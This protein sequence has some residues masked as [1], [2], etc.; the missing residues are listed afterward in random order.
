MRSLA[1]TLGRRISCAL[2]TC[3]KKEKLE[4]TEEEDKNKE[5]VTVMLKRPVSSQGGQGSLHN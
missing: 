3:D 5:E 4:E 2:R 1:A